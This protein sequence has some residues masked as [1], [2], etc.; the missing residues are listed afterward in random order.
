[1]GIVHLPLPPQDP[2]TRCHL[3][4]GTHS[5]LVSLSLYWKHISLNVRISC[6][7]N[8]L[9]YWHSLFYIFSNYCKRIEACEMRTKNCY[10]YYYNGSLL[11]SISYKSKTYSAVVNKLHLYFLCWIDP[12]IWILIAITIHG[13]SYYSAQS[14]MGQ[15]SRFLRPKNWCCRSSYR[16]LVSWQNPACNP[17]YG[18]ASRRTFLETTLFLNALSFGQ[19]ETTMADSRTWS[20]LHLRSLSS[21][22]KDISRLSTG[23]CYWTSLVLTWLLC[24]VLARGS[25]DQARG[26]PRNQ[27]P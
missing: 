21:D 27:N 18:P 26:T 4:L 14:S 3:I 12:W 11:D 8:L 15:V 2:G 22:Q 25:C 16:W 10:Y 19:K 1:M 17:R 6:I 23:T 13:W 20:S 24:S 9:G 5:L 7:C